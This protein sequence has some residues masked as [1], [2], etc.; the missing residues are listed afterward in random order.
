DGKLMV[1]DYSGGDDIAILTRDANGNITNVQRG[2]AGLVHYT[3]PLDL[4][5][6]PATGFLYVAEFGGQRLTLVR[7]ITPGANSKTDKSLMV[8]NDPT[9]SGSSAAQKIT[10]TNTGTAA[11]AFPSDGFTITG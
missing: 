11:L 1:A 4:V 2:I 10:I 5:E 3:D 8:F 7:P 9:T 6:N